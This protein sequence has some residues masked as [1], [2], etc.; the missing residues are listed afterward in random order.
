MRLSE[1]KY[2]DRVLLRA[3]IPIHPFAACAERLFLRRFVI[4]MAL[5]V[6]ID[7]A[8]VIDEVINEAAGALVASI[9]GVVSAANACVHASGLAKPSLTSPS[10]FA[11]LRG[12]STSLERT[13]TRLT[14][15]SVS[16]LAPSKERIADRPSQGVLTEGVN[17]EA[18][19]W[20][21]ALNDSV[22]TLREAEAALNALFSIPIEKLRT[23]ATDALAKSAAGLSTDVFPIPQKEVIVFCNGLNTTFVDE[24]GGVV[25]KWA[26]W[27]A[28]RSFALSCLLMPRCRSRGNRYWRR[29]GKWRSF[30][31]AAFA[32]EFKAAR[33]TARRPRMGRVEPH[34]RAGQQ[35]P[36]SLACE[37]RSSFAKT[38]D[39][40]LA[41]Y[42]PSSRSSLLTN[43]S[44]ANPRGRHLVRD[45]HYLP[46]CAAVSLRR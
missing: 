16:L 26:T 10:F 33:F 35:D 25:R 19:D 38:F 6:L 46:S 28:S 20:M 23:V 9:E 37:R 44:L 24:L 15:T 27:G 12:P 45:V 32:N 3:S 40:P 39:R 41:R 36:S 8:K 21:M 34:I 2:A 22:P 31:L 14:S 42:S 11:G 18:A 5:N 7:A 30:D 4:R 29:R 1:S 17:I 13:L 43:R